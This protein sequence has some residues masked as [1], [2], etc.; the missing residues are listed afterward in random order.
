MSKQYNL[1][2]ERHF[3]CRVRRCKGVCGYNLQRVSQE[4]SVMFTCP[5]CGKQW[6]ATINKAKRSC[7]GNVVVKFS[8][9]EKSVSKRPIVV[10]ER[11]RK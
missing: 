8:S 11:V 4:G 2:Y 6:S 5:Q 7:C 1:A 3:R 10:N 9:V